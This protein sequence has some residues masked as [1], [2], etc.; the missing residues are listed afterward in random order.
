MPPL[1]SKPGPQEILLTFQVLDILLLHKRIKP[2][3]TSI[4]SSSKGPSTLNYK[5]I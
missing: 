1:E 4:G 3:A 5:K 2:V